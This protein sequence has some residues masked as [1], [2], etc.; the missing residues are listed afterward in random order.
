MG[1]ATVRDELWMHPEARAPSC[2]SRIGPSED[3][4]L[5]LVIA[6]ITEIPELMSRKSKQL[7]RKV[8]Q[9]DIRQ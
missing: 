4:V 2:L 5:L 7:P 1:A 3:A 8:V 9:E 6:Q